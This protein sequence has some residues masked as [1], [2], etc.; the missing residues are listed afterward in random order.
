MR[1][2]PREDANLNQRKFFKKTAKGKVIKSKRDALL[3]CNLSTPSVIRERYLRDDV[4]CGIEQ[5]S[6]CKES[7]KRPLSVISQ[8]SHKAY[9]HGHF[10]I[11]DTNVLLGQVR[12][13]SKVKPKL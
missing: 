5:C 12:Q 3:G 6:L 10:V 4:P 9:S 8:A 1:K 11:P 2:R 13:D 7:N